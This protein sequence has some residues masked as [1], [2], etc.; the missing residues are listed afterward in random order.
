MGAE[1]APQDPFQTVV[2]DMLAHRD[3]ILG[4]FSR[5][6]DNHYEAWL[7]TKPLTLGAGASTLRH[8]QGASRPF[9]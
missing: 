9:S 6:D 1:R 5:A 2:R 8:R 7:V 4:L 3:R